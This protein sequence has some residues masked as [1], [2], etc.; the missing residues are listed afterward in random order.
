MGSH[1]DA[2]AVGVATFGLF[3]LIGALHDWH[4]ITGEYGFVT[5]GCSCDPL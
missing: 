1:A 3:G 2:E 5:V 4:I